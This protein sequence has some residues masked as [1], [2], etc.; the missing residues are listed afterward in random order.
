MV[1]KK[2]GLWTIAIE[3]MKKD[4]SDT[5]KDSSGNW[6]EIF[7]MIQNQWKFLSRH[8]RGKFCLCIVWW[9]YILRHIDHSSIALFLVPDSGPPHWDGHSKLNFW[10]CFL[11][12]P[13]FYASVIHLFPLVLAKK[14]REREKGLGDLLFD[15]TLFLPSKIDSLVPILFLVNSYLLWM[16]CMWTW[17]FVFFLLECALLSLFSTQIKKL[18][19]VFVWVSSSLE[20]LQSPLGC[21]WTCVF[22]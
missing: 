4:W 21:S 18:S 2:F 14:E 1:E 6:N 12:C 10:L 9:Q 11:G 15:D 19:L 22:M 17:F 3:S 7:F 5:S 16:H 8:W 20:L 13:L